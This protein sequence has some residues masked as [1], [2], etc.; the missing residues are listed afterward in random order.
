MANAMPSSLVTTT[1]DPAAPHS[2]PW[3]RWSLTV[4]AV[5]FLPL[6]VI[7]PAAN[8]FSQAFSKGV[9]A[10]VQDFFPAQAPVGTRPSHA[11][12][13]QVGQA[14]QTW[15]SIRMTVGV[16]AIA[17]PINLVFG[18]SAAWLIAKFRFKGRSLLISLIDL[19]F[20]VSPVVAGL[21]FVLMVRQLGDAFEL[22]VPRNRSGADLPGASGPSATSGQSTPASSSRRWRRSLRRCSSRSRSSPAI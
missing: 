14:E 5:T 4:I 22:G 13:R 19:P 7:L 10:Y 8:V 3:A 20:S 9:S 6:F 2:S 17:V 18:I 1:A 16:A 11:Q 15:A 21:I 12:R